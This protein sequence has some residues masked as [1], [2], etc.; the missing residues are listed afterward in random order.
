MSTLQYG[1]LFD[2]AWYRMRNRLPLIAGVTL[3]YLMACSVA[4][5]FPVAG[6]IL[7]AVFHAG[8]MIS[9]IKICETNQLG[10]EDFF[11]AFT[12]GNRLLQLILLTL[13]AAI[14][15]AVGFICLVIPGVYLSVAMFLAFPYFVTKNQDA[16]ESIKASLRMTKNHWWQMLGLL[17]LVALLNLAGALCFGIGVLLSIPMSMLILVEACQVLDAATPGQTVTVN[18]NVERTDF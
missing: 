16:V 8:Y 7:T 2:R 5:G 15:I 13:I 9:V 4:G 1:D 6:A 12:D 17:I 14:A 18:S 3:L 10:F 11:W